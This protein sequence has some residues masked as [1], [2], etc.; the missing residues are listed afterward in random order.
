MLILSAP[1]SSSL[2]SSFR[3]ASV[4]MSSFLASFFA[5]LSSFLA[6]SF[7]AAEAVPPDFGVLDE[8]AELSV[9]AASEPQAEP[10]APR[11]TAKPRTHP[12]RFQPF[13]ESLLVFRSEATP[14]SHAHAGE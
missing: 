4:S 10:T 1:A 12:L 3:R 6:S 8:L 5:S 11:Q 9:L 2:L 7:F 13:I 14:R